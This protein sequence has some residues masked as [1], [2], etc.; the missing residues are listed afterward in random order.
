MGGR[1]HTGEEYGKAERNKG[2]WTVTQK[3]RKSR[4]GG[5]T[6]HM[7][8]GKRNDCNA[9]EDMKRIS[10]RRKRKW[11]AKYVTRRENEKVGK[12]WLLG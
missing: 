10:V 8:G 9:E 5:K 3:T 6:M 12:G 1:E 2:T 11:K 7:R 4:K